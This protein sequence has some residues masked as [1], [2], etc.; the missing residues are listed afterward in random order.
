MIDRL[1]DT[2]SLPILERMLQFAGARHRLIA[3]NV[4]NIDTPDFRPVDVD[5]EVFQS[6]LD[7]AIESR[8]A[9]GGRGGLDLRSGGGLEFA[10]RGV[11]LRP[12]PAGDNVLFHDLNDRDLERMVQDLVE[13]FMSF[14]LAADLARGQYDTLRTAI[15][16]RL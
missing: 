4:A 3:H 10:E 12:E 16:G 1:T 11:V 14:R 6:R 15:A 5:P 7:E 8:R 9:R 13:N 2:G